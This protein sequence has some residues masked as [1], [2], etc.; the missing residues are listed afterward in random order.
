M[1]LS[2]FVER[3]GGRGRGRD[4]EGL[5]IHRCALNPLKVYTQTDK[6]LQQNPWTETVY[7]VGLSKQLLKKFRKLFQAL[8]A[9]QPI[10]A[11][12]FISGQFV[13]INFWPVKSGKVKGAKFC[14]ALCHIGC[15]VYLFWP[16]M[17]LLHMSLAYVPNKPEIES[18]KCATSPSL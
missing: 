8:K 2:R 5:I 6:K 18:F 7:Q 9:G 12:N 16:R 1:E 4:R 10:Q 3:E 13:T 15:L 17:L 14:C 11:F